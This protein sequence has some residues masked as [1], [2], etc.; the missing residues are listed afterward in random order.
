M[1]NHTEKLES[2][3]LIGC[4]YYVSIK[5]VRIGRVSIRVEIAYLADVHDETSEVCYSKNP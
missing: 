2:D 3:C 1:R 5:G 4:S